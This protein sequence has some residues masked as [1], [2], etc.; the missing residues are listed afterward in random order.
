MA[1]TCA[2]HYTNMS[3]ILK[4]IFNEYL[5]RLLLYY[6]STLEANLE[7]AEAVETQKKTKNTKKRKSFVCTGI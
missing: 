2:N 3:L 5:N 6:M 4:R 1:D 7:A